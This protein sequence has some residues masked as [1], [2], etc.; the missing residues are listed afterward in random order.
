MANGSELCIKLISVCAYA[1][2]TLGVYPSC[3]N[4]GQAKPR[5]SWV[6]LYGVLHP[7]KS[8]YQS[9]EFLN[10]FKNLPTTLILP[11][12]THAYP[13]LPC[14]FK[15]SGVLALPYLCMH[16]LPEAP[17]SLIWIRAC[18]HWRASGQKTTELYPQS[19]EVF[20]LLLVLHQICPASWSDWDIRF[21]EGPVCMDN[22]REECRIDGISWVWNQ[23]KWIIIMAL[24]GSQTFC[25]GP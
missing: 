8:N 20:K 4:E 18:L 2:V 10:M 11:R 19:H 17:W 21:C 22:P 5:V 24:K 23:D 16:L 15:A 6:V 12:T 1:P 14:F 9:L 13:R 25:S 3:V 7:R